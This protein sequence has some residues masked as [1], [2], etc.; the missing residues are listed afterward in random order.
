MSVT[1][2][3]H[4]KDDMGMVQQLTINTFFQFSN[5]KMLNMISQFLNLLTLLIVIP[6][7]H[8]KRRFNHVRADKSLPKAFFSLN[9]TK[10]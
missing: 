3:K 1:W 10:V 9:S 7:S 4:A 2:G 5:I 8:D 6:Q